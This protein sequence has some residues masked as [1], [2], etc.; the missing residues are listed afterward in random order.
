MKFSA[1][2][3]TA[4]AS[5]V[6]ASTAPA[7]TT[8][9]STIHL[10]RNR[11]LD[12]ECCGGISLV[13]DE[14][15]FWRSVPMG[16]QCHNLPNHREESST[17]TDVEL[18][19]PDLMPHLKSA[20]TEPNS[21]DH[22][23][24]P[25]LDKK[26]IPVVSKTILFCNNADIDEIN[27]CV[28]S[29]LEQNFCFPRVSSKT[30]LA[31]DSKWT[32]TLTQYIRRHFSIDLDVYFW[33]LKD[34]KSIKDAFRA[35]PDDAK[36][37][38]EFQ[39][40]GGDGFAWLDLLRDITTGIMQCSNETMQFTQNSK[41]IDRICSDVDLPSDSEDDTCDDRDDLVKSIAMLVDMY[42]RSGLVGRLEAL[43]MFCRMCE[44]QSQCHQ[45][46]NDKF[47]CEFVTT[48]LIDVSADCRRSG[49]YAPL[50]RCA[51]TLLS[52][53]VESAG[54]DQ[55]TTSAI[56]LELGSNTTMTNIMLDIA[57]I[58]GEDSPTSCQ[59]ARN[60]CAKLVLYM[61]GNNVDFAWRETVLEA[62]ATAVS[63]PANDCK[64]LTNTLAQV[65]HTIRSLNYTS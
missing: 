29:V 14:D 57:D 11:A 58:I 45:M 28:I 61:V 7:S 63:N 41:P 4:P 8:P 20:I 40:L 33:E 49:L 27:A 47:F 39:R 54:N 3:S 44:N 36:F 55:A 24:P 64:I 50:L 25:Q 62:V 65:Q 52:Y 10:P 19:G 32:L 1:P 30:E 46:S 23:T 60:E 48:V 42:Y 17:R 22:S 43:K 53:L 9:A 6:P 15:T 51:V 18:Q 13:S 26:M 5:T 59:A 2:A 37:A 21:T 16:P 38:I 34:M 35:C 12:G 56:V 31:T